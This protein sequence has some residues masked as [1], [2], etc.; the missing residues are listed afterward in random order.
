M[1]EQQRTDQQRKALEKWCNMCAAELN[2]QGIPYHI[3]ISK[4]MERG[5]ET[6]W[7]QGNFKGLF[8]IILCH[9]YPDYDSTADAG[10]KEYNVIYEGLVKWF[11]QEEGAVLPPWPDRFSQAMEFNKEL[12][13]ND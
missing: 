7:D 13:K 6:M 3:V 4:I 9:V 8:R 5:I 11:G 2:R 1:N 12:Y 10:T